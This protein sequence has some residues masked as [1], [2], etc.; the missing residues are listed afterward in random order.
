MINILKLVNILVT[1]IHIFNT[2]WI[3]QAFYDKQFW[4]TNI[5]VYIY[6]NIWQIM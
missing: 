1:N 4:L 3:Q 6:E 5:L 2:L